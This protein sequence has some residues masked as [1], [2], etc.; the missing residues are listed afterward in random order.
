MTNDQTGQIADATASELPEY[1]RMI[2]E[3]ER[4]EIR[5]R[6]QAYE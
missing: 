4:H 2:F 6:K 1:I 3:W 5:L